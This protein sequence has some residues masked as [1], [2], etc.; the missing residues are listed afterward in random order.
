MARGYLDLRVL[1]I[2]R[3][4]VAEWSLAVGRHD[5]FTPST[6]DLLHLHSHEC[7]HV[8]LRP[9]SWVFSIYPCD[10]FR[11]ADEL[12]KRLKGV[13][14]NATDD[15]HA[16]FDWLHRLGEHISEDPTRLPAVSTQFTRAFF[17]IMCFTRD[18]S[19]WA[20]ASYLYPEPPPSSSGPSATRT[21]LASARQVK[22]GYSLLWPDLAS[23]EFSSDYWFQDKRIGKPIDDPDDA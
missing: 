8:D 14:R 18:M 16:Y 21:S 2:W 19:D 4:Q 17:K 12:E 1:P 10:A 22:P 13:A 9:Q 20:G 15:G 11:L 23:D 3:H 5:W 6:L 7:L